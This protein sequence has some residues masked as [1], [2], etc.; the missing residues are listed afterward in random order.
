MDSRDTD[1]AAVLREK[2]RKLLA[3]AERGLPGE[4]AVALEKARRLAA[5]LGLSDM[6]AAELETRGI[7]VCGKVRK[8]EHLCAAAICG[9][10]FDVSCC[11]VGAREKAYTFD[12]REYFIEATGKPSALFFAEYVA[13]FLVRHWQF[14]W[15]YRRG[16]CRNNQRNPF[17]RGC[18]S[19][20]WNVLVE[21]R[22][23]GEPAAEIVVSDEEIDAVE[24]ARGKTRISGAGLRGFLIGRQ[25]RIRKPLSGAGASEG[26][27]AALEGRLL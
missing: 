1:K 25:T 27:I 8:T 2:L 3:L 15:E 12:E 16:K 22:R 18:Y 17:I 9:E 23:A 20:L 10:F 24:S 6:A 14:L 11:Y 26:A 5:E 4:A 21:E 13:G 19:G 7:F